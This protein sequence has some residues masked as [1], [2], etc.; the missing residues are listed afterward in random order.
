M[1]GICGCLPTVITN[2]GLPNLD[3]I[4]KVTE[5]LSRL[6]AGLAH[7]NFFSHNFFSFQFQLEFTTLLCFQQDGLVQKN[8]VRGSNPEPVLGAILLWILR[9]IFDLLGAV[10]DP[11]ICTHSGRHAEFRQYPAIEYY[12]Y[13]DDHKQD[14][15]IFH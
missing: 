14:P 12:P 4:T 15:N 10:P 9:I 11:T 7:L 8:R 3:R 13:D 1:A 5:L 6:T 2:V